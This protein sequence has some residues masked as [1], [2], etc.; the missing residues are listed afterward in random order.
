M[1]FS[2]ESNISVTLL[3]KRLE[4]PLVINMTKKNED[5]KTAFV[6]SPMGD[7]GSEIRKRADA[8]LRYVIEPPLSEC[9]YKAV[10]ADKI[11]E[12]GIITS[13]IITH[14]MNDPLV[15]ADLTGHN[16][17]VFYE[18]AVRHAIKKPVVQLIQKG[19]RIPFDI[20]TTR[21]IQI[22]HTDLQSVAEAI[23]ELTR[24]IRAVEKDP[25]KVDSPISI[26]VDL[27]LLKQSADPQRK[28][29][30]EMRSMMQMIY[31]STVDIRDGLKEITQESRRPRLSDLVLSQPERSYLTSDRQEMA[32]LS[33]LRSFYEERERKER[34]KKRKK[35]STSK[36]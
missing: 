1:A 27:E 29:L 35:Q 11:S 2:V 3:I 8:I 10:R 30:A 34:E 15:V 14:I 5:T 17:N 26:A 12:P 20:S 23:E 21:T 4:N 18:L 6:I 9:G 7:P 19:E 31:A 16:P 32:R 33:D 22:D 28:T 36:S 25:S 13:Q 24:Q